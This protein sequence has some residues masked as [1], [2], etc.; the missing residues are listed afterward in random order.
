MPDSGRPAAI[1]GEPGHGSGR[2]VGEN[3]EGDEG[4]R[5]PPS[6]WV[7]AAR[8][9]GS[10]GGDGLEVAVIGGG[11]TP[12]LRK[13]REAAVV[14]RDEAGSGVGLLIAGVRRFGGEIFVL[15]STL[16]GPWWPAG[17]PVAGRWDSSCR[18]TRRLDGDGTTQAGGGTVQA[19]AMK[20]EASLVVL[21][22]RRC[23]VNV[24]LRRRLA[25]TGH[26]AGPACGTTSSN[27]EEGEGGRCGVP[28]R[29]RGRVY[30]ENQARAR[31]AV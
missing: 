28:Q 16:A 24:G 3:G 14:V 7:G 21:G 1:A 10:T 13:G 22:W 23:G 2:G 12:V 31:G 8:G 26:V 29:A 17:I 19:A 25:A 5:F 20:G 30:G 15:V 6:P 18:A 11:G 27:E 9:G 4:D